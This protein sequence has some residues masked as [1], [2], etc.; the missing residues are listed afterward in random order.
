M[1]IFVCLGAAAL[2]LAATGCNDT[3]STGSGGETTTTTGTAGSSGSTSSQGG[4]GTGGDTGGTGGTTGGTG[5][6]GGTTGGTGGT[7]GA[8]PIASGLGDFVSA[9]GVCES[10]SYRLVHAFGQATPNQG[11]A[12][13]SKY[14]LQGGVIGATGN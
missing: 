8:E 7:G 1:N 9:G 6:T 3:D 12:T 2:A 13:S 4:G 10:P 5:G 14:R 11:N